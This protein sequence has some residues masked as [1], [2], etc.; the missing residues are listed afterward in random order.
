MN[1][2]LNIDDN[3]LDNA[4][5]LTGITDKNTLIIAGLEALLT[6][7]H[8]RRVSDKKPIKKSFPK[9]YY[10]N[11]FSKSSYLTPN[12]ALSQLINHYGTSLCEEPKRCEALLRDSCGGKHQREISLLVNALK[13]KITVNLLNPPIWLSK[14]QLFFHLTARLHKGLGLD[15]K[16]S[17]WAVS[18]WANSLDKI[19]RRFRLPLRILTI[20]VVIV[21]ITLL[22]LL[23]KP[24]V[25]T[26]V[27]VEIIVPQVI[28]KKKPKIVQAIKTIPLT[29]RS[30][31]YHDKVF[32]NGKAYGATPLYNIELAPGLYT[33]RVKKPNYIP[34][35]QQINLQ[36]TKIIRVKL[37]RKK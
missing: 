33:L 10:Q 17:A 30:N 28:E 15:K 19:S 32:I 9:K 31:V 1:T 3:L 4:S 25:T 6:K 34:F 24:E 18:T 23:A 21:A 27:K 14:N 29:I 2:N 37:R 8:Q 11:I 13:E 5:E 7:Q 36:K 20:S 12:K 22:F 26:Q 16:L 35:E